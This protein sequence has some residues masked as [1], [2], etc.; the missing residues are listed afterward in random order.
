MPEERRSSDCNAPLVR[1]LRERFDGVPGADDAGMGEAERRLREQTLRLMR[2][3]TASIP[4][5]RS[6]RRVGGREADESSAAP[7]SHRISGSA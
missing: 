2:G 6:L 5:T 4:G 3:Q 7:Q 1:W